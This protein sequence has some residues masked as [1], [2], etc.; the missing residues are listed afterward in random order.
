MGFSHIHLVSFEKISSHSDHLP[1]RFWMFLDGCFLDRSPK[2]LRSKRFL[3]DPYITSLGFADRSMF[4]S[5]QLVGIANNLRTM[6]ETHEFVVPR[7][8]PITSPTSSDLNR[9]AIPSKAATDMLGDAAFLAV[10]AAALRRNS[11]EES[12]L[13]CIAICIKEDLSFC[14]LAPKKYKLPGVVVVM[15]E[16]WVRQREV[17]SQ[18]RM[19][20]T[21]QRMSE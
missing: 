10:S 5:I 18:T 19:H 21:R 14:K 1:S 7:S 12:I 11:V 3:S 8:I 13:L 15:R 9:R 6:M 16:G 4:V 17:F 20:H 2:G